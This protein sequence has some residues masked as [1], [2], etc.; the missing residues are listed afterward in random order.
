M[1]LT[2]FAKR[3]IKALFIGGPPRTYRGRPC[4]GSRWR[5]EF[6]DAEKRQVRTFLATFAEAFAYPESEK[7]KFRPDDAVYQVYRERYRLSGW[8]DA[9]ELERLSQLMQ[10]RYHIALRDLWTETLTL[11][12]L[13][14]AART[15]ADGGPK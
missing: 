2:S 11:G 9:G 12:E 4:Q 13:F 7:L 1:S 8:A 3:L 5:R 6:P 10:K 14:E 15:K